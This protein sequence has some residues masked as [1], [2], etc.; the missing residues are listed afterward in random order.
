MR[1]RESKDTDEQRM[2]CTRTNDGR[3]ERRAARM[4]IILYAP[5][6]RESRPVRLHLV[7]L[8]DGSSID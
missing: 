4:A 5:G 1:E 3:K 7:R 8:V 2:L 6:L